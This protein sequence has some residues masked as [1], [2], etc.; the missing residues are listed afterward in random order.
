MLKTVMID[1]D[2]VLADWVFGFRKLAQG[3][4]GVPLYG[5]MRQQSWTFPDLNPKQV[6]HLWTLIKDSPDFWFDLKPLPVNKLMLAAVMAE[7]T[8]YFCTSRPGE[9]A[10]SQTEEWLFHQLLIVCPTVVICD[11]KGSFAEAV[12]ADFA[13]DDRLENVLSI[14]D[15]SP[16]TRAYLLDRP[17]NVDPFGAERGYTRVQCIED[18][19]D[20]VQCQKLH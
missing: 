15:Y 3:M 12:A 14:A 7:N 8:V 18:F 4:Y 2:G 11:R 17:Y 19:F 10:K 5:T 1:V 20:A 9:T 13:I 6:D 16:S